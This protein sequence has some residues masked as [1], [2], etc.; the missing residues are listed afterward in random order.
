M[1]TVVMMA[2]IDLSSGVFALNV[3]TALKPFL[4]HGL[5]HVPRLLRLHRDDALERTLSHV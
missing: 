2:R 4:E 3:L 5:K 1:H